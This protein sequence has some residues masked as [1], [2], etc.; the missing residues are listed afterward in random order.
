MSRHRSMWAEWATTFLEQQTVK[1]KVTSKYLITWPHLQ[2]CTCILLIISEGQWLIN[3]LI[4]TLM[5]KKHFNTILMVNKHFYYCRGQT[6]SLSVAF[7]SSLFL[8]EITYFPTQVTQMAALLQWYDGLKGNSSL[9]LGK[10]LS[11]LDERD[12]DV[13]KQLTIS[14]S[15]WWRKFGNIEAFLYPKWDNLKVLTAH[16]NHKF[17]TLE[18]CL[19]PLN[20][21]K[22]RLLLKELFLTLSSPQLYD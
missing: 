12:L 5:L 7:W 20:Q 9:H 6:L 16:E 10:V 1:I 14:A 2:S 4:D 18:R 8:S 21:A 22:T 11:R 15:R 17:P 19:Y 13:L 3:T